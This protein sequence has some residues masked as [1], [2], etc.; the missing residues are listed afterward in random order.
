MA[1]VYRALKHVIQKH[2]DDRQSSKVETFSIKF[3]PISDLQS[4]L[5]G[6]RLLLQQN[7]FLYFYA[8]AKNQ[9]LSIEITL[10]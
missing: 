10:F 1:V 2:S 3:F 8:K 6:T 7:I 5:W 4:F 9:R